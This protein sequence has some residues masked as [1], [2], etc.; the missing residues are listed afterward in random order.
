MFSFVRNCHAVFQS[1]CTILHP[2][3]QW[4]RVPL[5][6]HPAFDVV[7]V[8]D[9]EHS[10]CGTVSNYCF[11]ML[12]MWTYVVEH[13]FICFF[14]IFMSSLVRCLLK[15]LAYFL[16]RLCLVGI[17]SVCFWVWGCFWLHSFWNLSSLTR[18]W[19][20]A[21][22]SGSTGVLTTRPPGNSQS[23]CFLIVEF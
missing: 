21:L 22:C 4:T 23:G 16:I 8:L 5:A 7:H 10:K 11:N 9:F 12:Y 17:L 1:R 19:T 18:D 3:Q 13:L 6:S 2:H 15:S 14:A 20:L